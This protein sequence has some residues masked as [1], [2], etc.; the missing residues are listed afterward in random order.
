[1]QGKWQVSGYACPRGLRYALDELDSPKRMVSTSL[2]VV[3]GEYQMVSVR[4]DRPIPKQMILPAMQSL[5]GI[6]VSAP[7]KRDQII[8]ENWL[9]MGVNLIATRTVAA[10][11]RG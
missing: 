1:M 4:P 5:H 7:V 10:V 6:A 2:P 3:G 11:S 9:G 8:I